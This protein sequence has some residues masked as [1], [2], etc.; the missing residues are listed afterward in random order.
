M[1]GIIV[2]GERN[3]FI[4]DPF[5]Q[6]F[7]FN[8]NNYYGQNYGDAFWKCIQFQIVCDIKLLLCDFHL[9]YTAGFSFLV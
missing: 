8:K 1:V 7:D 3:S 5:S 2:Y 4:I 6:Y 9:K